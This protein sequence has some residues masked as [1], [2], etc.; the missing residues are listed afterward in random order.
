MRTVTGSLPLVADRQITDSESANAHLPTNCRHT[1]SPIKLTVEP[2][3]RDQIGWNESF[4]FRTRSLINTFQPRWQFVLKVCDF[5][6]RLDRSVLEPDSDG[7][8][9]S[10]VGA[11]RIVSTTGHYSP[12]F[13]G[14]R[15]ANNYP[16][17]GQPNA[18]R[19]T[20]FSIRLKAIE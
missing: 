4:R 6:S 18:L 16:V 17:N 2:S 12:I 11:T 1:S 10:S 3:T 19:T 14:Y 5:E 8:D 7:R 9:K 20:K 15:L 13:G